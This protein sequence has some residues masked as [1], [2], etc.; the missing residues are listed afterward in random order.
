MH[1]RVIVGTLVAV[2]LAAG[3]AAVAATATDPTPVGDAA[4]LRPLPSVKATTPLPEAPVSGDLSN[5][6]GPRGAAPFTGPAAT[7]KPAPSSSRELIERRTTNSETWQNDDGSQT[8]SMS[9]APKYYEVN[10]R[11]ER[12]DNTVVV[13]DPTGAL[14]NAA[15][16]WSVRFGRLS[17]GITVATD[18]GGTTFAPEG[19]ADVAPVAGSGAQANTVTYRDAWPGV[20]LV[21]RVTA[22]AV[23]EDI[24]LRRRPTSSAFA[25]RTSGSR[26]FVPDS[27]AFGALKALGAGADVA[28]APPE[29]LDRN[30]RSVDKSAK[31][32]QAATRGADG[33]DR[34]TVA[35]DAGF[36]ASVAD[37]QFPIVIDPTVGIVYSDWESY[38]NDGYVWSYDPMRIGNIVDYNP[39]HMYRAVAYFDYPQLF[40][41][42][43]SA[44][45][46]SASRDTSLSGTANAVSAS[47]YNATG[48]CYGCLG[49]LQDTQSFGD[50]AT[51][52]VTNLYKGWIE[53]NV[54]GGYVAFQG[55]EQANYFS[56]KQFNATLSVTY[57]PAA[58]NPVPPTTPVSPADQSVTSSPVPTLTVNAVTDPQ[59]AAV[60]YWYRLTTSADAETGM[61]YNSGWVTSTSLTL[62]SSV[63]ENGRT[64]YWHTYTLARGNVGNPNWVRSFRYDKRLGL[65]DTQPYDE[66]G[67]AKLNLANGNL[68]IQTGSHTVGGLAGD[69]GV[70]LTYN[71][72]SPGSSGLQAQYWY[73]ITN[74]HQS[75]NDGQPALVRR[76]PQI[77]FNWSNGSPAPVLDGDHF[78]AHW[79]GYLTVDVTGTYAFGASHDD[80]AQILINNQWVMNQWCDCP[81][82][83]YGN[84]KVLTAGQPVPIEVWSYENAGSASM[85]L[86]AK[87]PNYPNGIVA[88]SS[89]FSTAPTSLPAGWSFGAV[90]G[91][92]LPLMSAAVGDSSVV[93]T[94]DTGARVEYK[95]Q[96]G[97]GSGYIPPRGDDSTLVAN[98][99]HTLTLVDGNWAYRFNSDGTLQSAVSATDDLSTASFTYLYTGDPARLTKI[100][101]PV[102]TRTIDISYGGDSA[103]PT[104]PPK[105]E[106]AVAPNALLCQVKSWDNATTKFWY[107]IS[108]RLVRVEGPGDGVIGHDVTDFGYDA[109][110]RIVTVRDPLQADTVAA[111]KTA[112]DAGSRTN[113]TSY[114]SGHTSSIQLGN[115]PKHS[116][117]YEVGQ[118]HVAADGLPGVDFRKVVVDASGRIYQDYDATGKMTTTIWD[119]PDRVLAVADPTGRYAVKA[120]DE[121][122]RLTDT[123]GPANASC[124]SGNPLRPN[125][126]CFNP[127]VA[128]TFAAYDEGITGLAVA[129]WNNTTETGPVT[130]HKTGACGQS[131]V[132]CDWG[133]GSPATGI[134]TDAWSMRMTGEITLSSTGDWK[135]GAWADGFA[136]IYVD[137]RLV[138]ISGVPEPGG[139]APTVPVNGAFTN[140]TAN[141]KHRLR[142]DYAD[143]SGNAAISFYWLPPAG[144][145]ALVPGTS[146]GPRYGLLTTAK[147]FDT[148]MPTQVTTLAYANPETGLATSST[149]GGLTA[150][151]VY[152]SAHRWRRSSQTMPTGAISTYDYYGDNEIAVSPCPG[153]AS[154]N[155]GGRP[156][157]TTAPDPDGAGAALPRVEQA[158]FDDV[159]RV[160]ATR[161]TTPGGSNPWTCSSYDA[162]GRVTSR[163]VPANGAEAPRTVTY[164]YAVVADLSTTGDP[165]ITSVTDS[166]GAITTT[167][168]NLGRVT[169]YKD[170]WGNTTTTS[171]DTIGRVAQTSG[172]QGVVAATYD[173]AGRPT[174]VKL[175]GSVLARVGYDAGGRATTLSYPSNDGVSTNGVEA[176]NGTEAAGP[177]AYDTAGS[178]SSLLWRKTVGQT[179]ITQNSVQ[180]S[181]SGKVYEESVD[182]VDPYPTGDNYTYDA[183]GRLLSAK[184]GSHA[185]TYAFAASGGCGYQTN[186]GLNTNRTSRSD[187]VSGVTTTATFCYDAADRLTSSTPDLTTGIGYDTHGNTASLGGQTLIYDG[188]DRHDETRLTNAATRYVRDATDRIVAR[189]ATVEPRTAPSVAHVTAA[190]SAAATKPASA[191]VGDVLV[192]EVTV[193]GGSGTSVTPPSGWTAVSAD[194]GT[195]NAAGSALRDAIYTHVLGASDPASWNFG[196]NTAVNATAVVTAYGGVD[197]TSPVVAS[198]V[199]AVASATVATAPGVTTSGLYNEL[200][201]TFAST[202]LPVTG[203]GGAM[204]TRIADA[205]NALAD[206]GYDQAQLDPGASGTRTST[207]A[208]AVPSVAHLLALRPMTFRYGFAAGGDAPAFSQAVDGSL[209]QRS[210]GLPGGVVVTKRVAGDTWSYPNLHGDVAAAA[211][212]NGAK[213][214]QTTAYDPDGAPLAAIVDNS[215]GNYDN[216]WLGS[217]SR[218]NEHQPGLRNVIEMGARIYDP[219]L[220]RFLE[221][222]PVEGGSANDYD[223]VGGDPVNRRDF[224]GLYADLY[225]GGTAVSYSDAPALAEVIARSGYKSKAVT[226]F[227]NTHSGRPARVS[228]VLSPTFGVHVAPVTPQARPRPHR[229][230][231]AVAVVRRNIGPCIIGGVMTAGIAF[232]TGPGAL[233]AGAQGCAQ[234]VVINEI[235]RATNQREAASSLDWFLTNVVYLGVRIALME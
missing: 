27:R 173:N 5:P 147:V 158:V 39:G 81:A 181:T 113:I 213:I 51:F 133:A 172:P 57:N 135:F 170:V 71:S 169:Q 198:A 120:Y 102:T 121:Q 130:L 92:S 30:S 208:S 153:G 75:S 183:A 125:G 20:D 63:L 187:T 167:V 151:T 22:T 107:D 233:I 103:C 55:W 194:S 12:I 149:I 188:A 86:M 112:D 40:G 162:R 116:Y 128:H 68:V 225:G 209:I 224:T 234:S 155:Q 186:A 78:I 119:A 145:W 190:S 42:T 17:E 77:A 177:L 229:Q 84:S 7:P 50:S 235:G 179:T 48:F 93:F 73:D 204:T 195:A 36:V 33:A 23:K 129:Y 45:S 203:P 67:P 54:S 58:P 3:S 35:V 115:G 142:I 94:T 89:W 1:R 110:S 69:A 96:T 180:R 164:N 207:Y 88:P 127:P 118:T 165:R 31:P 202:S 104:S 222:D 174:D 117:T 143:T 62:P 83:E 166:V 192:A 114:T 161:V 139:T 66:M 34:V 134:S 197:T 61:A 160:V 221:V 108:G 4:Q 74:D 154:Y 193:T 141:S 6:P 150:T 189:T 184:I 80:G 49:S 220:A 10:G 65:D 152:D 29:V 90:G 60:A 106:L 182:S 171:Y 28:V 56:L 47:V 219:G 99:D 87:T 206:A 217:R 24:V 38:R 223:Y 148:P 85:Y 43:V 199:S 18:N 191:Q 41:T 105:P 123:W 231:S 185:Y 159:G 131:N 137:D 101:D 210:V 70:G 168:D 16:G 200:V 227:I 25:F 126:T 205:A 111:T 211:D 9:S 44:A 64:Y 144:A 216:S 11:L 232:A 178:L 175:D 215:A 163:T 37:D 72:M 32:T 212:G 100:T 140:G 13:A 176:G 8:L 122:G 14:R 228:T 82:L 156:K 109:L 76:D 196:F 53:G 59:G 26:T 132:S 230:S 2:L 218:G 46:I 79:T 124:F 146:L 52:N 214:G 138:A 91:D 226:T 136:A 201:A 15:N 21:Y 98:P 157:S 97:G 95:K 19:V